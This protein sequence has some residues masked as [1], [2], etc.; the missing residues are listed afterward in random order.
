MRAPI[1]KDDAEASSGMQLFT[2][3]KAFSLSPTST[4]PT[5]AAERTFGVNGD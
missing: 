2:Q 3:S 1:L 5:H 4:T